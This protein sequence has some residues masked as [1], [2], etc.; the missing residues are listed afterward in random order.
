MTVRLWTTT[1][2]EPR[3]RYPVD[4]W[5]PLLIVSPGPSGD[6]R[7]LCRSIGQLSDGPVEGK[8]RASVE[9]SEGRSGEQREYKSMGIFGLR[10]SSETPQNSCEE[11][12]GGGESRV[13]GAMSAGANGELFKMECVSSSS[14]PL[15]V[16]FSNGHRDDGERA[17][18][19]PHEARGGRTGGG[20]GGSTPLRFDP[21]TR[22]TPP[23]RHRS[24]PSRATPP[25]YANGGQGTASSERTISCLLTFL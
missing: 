19:Q 6:R 11:G 21:P 16:F 2:H 8:R 9:R 18:L 13:C 12:E 7:S 23:P 4:L 14:D 17:S 20:G 1:R 10:S 25:T 24:T 22:P 5:F 15:F 3:R